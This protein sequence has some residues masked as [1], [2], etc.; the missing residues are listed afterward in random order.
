[1]EEVEQKLVGQTGS[2]VQLLLGLPHFNRKREKNNHVTL[3]MF[4]GGDVSVIPVLNVRKKS[5]TC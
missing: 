3:S 5:S 2:V 1:M 4:T